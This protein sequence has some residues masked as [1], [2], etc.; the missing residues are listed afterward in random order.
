MGKRLG[1]AVIDE[2]QKEPGSF[3]KIKYAFDERGSVFALSGSAS[4]FCSGKSK[5]HLQG[6]S[7]YLNCFR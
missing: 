7:E 5:R 2:I 4:F 1:N 3:D 6:V